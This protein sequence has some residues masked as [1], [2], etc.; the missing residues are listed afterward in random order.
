ME[1]DQACLNRDISRTVLDTYCYI[2]RQMQYE[3]IRIDDNTKVNILQLTSSSELWKNTNLVL[4]NVLFSHFVVF[5]FI[6]KNTILVLKKIV[7]VVFV[8]H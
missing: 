7:F 1:L 4:S 5:L 2:T 6:H 3:L 8:M